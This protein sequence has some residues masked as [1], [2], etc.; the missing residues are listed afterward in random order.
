MSLIDKAKALVDE[1]RGPLSP[2]RV[3]G[4]LRKKRH[5]TKELCEKLKASEAEVM[6]LIHGMQD[7]N[8]LVYL[9]GKEWGVESAPSSDSKGHVY[10]S[11]PDGTYLFGFS[12]DQHLA[13][14]YSRLD[15]LNDLYDQF[16]Q[17]GV[18]RVLNAGN[19]ID[20]EARFNMHDLLVH[21]MDGQLEYMAEKYPQRE[22]IVTYAVAGDDHEGW[23]GQREGID[24]GKH[25]ESVMRGNGRMDWVNLGYMESF[26]ELK[27]SVTGKT[28]R[29]LLMH[30]GGGSS[31]ALCFD[32][33]TEIMT[34]R[35]FKKFKELLHGEDV[36]TLNQATHEWE[37]QQPT[38]YTDERYAGDL[39]HFG[40][41]DT[42]RYDLMVTPNHRMYCSRPHIGPRWDGWQFVPAADIKARSWQLYRGC[43]WVG[44]S[45][46]SISIPMATGKPKSSRLRNLDSFDPGDFMELVGWYLSEGTLS[47]AN[48]QVQI[49]Q[50]QGGNYERIVALAKR[51]GFNPYRAP[52]RVVITSKQLFEY[53]E[54]LG[55]SDQKHIPSNLKVLSQPLLHR[56]LEGYWLGDGNSF[57]DGRF[58]SAS[59]V[60][61]KL[62][63]DL[64]EV[65]MKCGYAATASWSPGA[66]GHSIGDGKPIQTAKPKWQ[67]S[68]SRSTTPTI[69]TEPTLVPYMGRVYCVTVPN[70]VIL[71]KRHGKICW[72][73]NS[74]KPQ[75][76]IE[77]FEGGE[78]PAAL[79]IGHYHKISYQV[80]RNVHAIQCGTT[81][82]QTPFMR[83]KG[84]QAH[85]GG[86]ICHLRQD[87]KTGALTACRIEFF[88][89][90]NAGH[91][92][93][94]WS[95]GGKATLP[96]RV[97][98]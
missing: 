41:G 92:S 28:A 62:M 40:G 61:A 6:A 30:P 8:V 82:D 38:A 75:K 51:L 66:I 50:N 96:K 97:R 69:E 46:A 12:S 20:G 47:K 77:G 79:L 19:W 70:G 68:V 27:H 23:Y 59:T 48:Q 15:C 5:T 35:G 1:K 32:D 11:R 76:I 71:V 54:P 91:Y 52:N 93:G 98:S 88:N 72:S 73:G 80:T 29:L 56:L 89:Y 49:C 81:Q 83:K 7:K 86:G 44:E 16:E 4:L 84:L 57:E 25:A 58:H 34:R 53:V 45:V 43:E 65:L 78:K 10:T 39:I 31:Y 26:I 67:L 24:I 37:W 17:Q 95:H 85:V 21:G 18:D 63:A 90:F 33:Q 36:A 3:I 9:F 42:G 55:C 87:P 94:R 64:V 13:S 22:G 74:Y 2:D 14:K 60:S